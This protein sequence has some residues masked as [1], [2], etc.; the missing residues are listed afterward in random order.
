MMTNALTN[1][2]SEKKERKAVEAFLTDKLVSQQL[3]LRAV[4][5]KKKKQTKKN[6]KKNNFYTNSVFT[7][8]LK[9]PLPQVDEDAFEDMI[10]TFILHFFLG[11]TQYKYMFSM[12]LLRTSP[13]D[14]YSSSTKVNYTLFFKFSTINFTF[15]QG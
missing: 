9:R 3:Y 13:D 2:F 8:S 10:Y 11:T 7:H 6:N 4:T 5:V 14:S 15:L 12:A 1:H